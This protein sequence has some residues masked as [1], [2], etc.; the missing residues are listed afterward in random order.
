MVNFLFVCAVCTAHW[1][2]RLM[3]RKLQWLRYKTNNDCTLHTLTKTSIISKN[4]NG[5]CKKKE[6]KAFCSTGYNKHNQV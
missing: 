1:H 3:Y 5:K 2:N 4:C 6:S